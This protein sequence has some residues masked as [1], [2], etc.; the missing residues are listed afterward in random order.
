MMAMTA[1]HWSP[2]AKLCASGLLF[3]SAELNSCELASAETSSC[4][5]GD[6]LLQVGHSGHLSALDKIVLHDSAE[7]GEHMDTLEAQ[8][9]RVTTFY[10][11][12]AMFLKRASGAQDGDQISL[13]SPPRA[14]LYQLKFPEHTFFSQWRQEEILWPTVLRP[15]TQYYLGGGDGT[16]EQRPF[17]VES[18]A[19][20]GEFHSNTLFL[21]REK[22][23]NGVL[24]EPST[25]EYPHLLEKQRKCYSWH[26]CL[27]PTGRSEQVQ[28]LDT[29]DGLSQIKNTTEGA[30]VKAESLLS[31]LQAIHN[32]S[33][34]HTVDFWSL[35][36]EG[37]EASVL[38]TTDFQAIE[39]GVLLI[40]M[41][42]GS[43]LNKRIRAVMKANRF[44]E[45]G[46]TKYV[47]DEPLD[48]VF[49]N[50]KYF[51]ARGIP[52]PQEVEG[53]LPPTSYSSM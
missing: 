30:I 18:G 53:L 31:L 35:D 52:V 1:L 41:N 39:F 10:G 8:A 2:L 6:S 38:E 40:E 37:S 25:E 20:D 32:E 3:A 44:E 17:F 15:I 24:I 46:G 5:T 4:S 19:R 45:I 34:A 50:P 48:I 21:E 42:K 22:G 33:A 9:M 49:V 23:W 26:G 47:G 11:R 16:Q 14:A 51:K 13:D 29:A 12:K 7:V 43:D 27:S 36:I 28:F